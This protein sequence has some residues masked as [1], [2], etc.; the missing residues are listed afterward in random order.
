MGCD[1][2]H[3]CHVEDDFDVWWSLENYLTRDLEARLRLKG[4]L[5]DD[6]T[7]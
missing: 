6:D 3:Q 7:R 4:L 1:C 2:G 5:L